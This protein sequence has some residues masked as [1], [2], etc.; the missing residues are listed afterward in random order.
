MFT[1]VIASNRLFITP[2][3]LLAQRRARA[4]RKLCGRRQIVHELYVDDVTRRHDHNVLQIDV[5]NANLR[6]SHIPIPLIRNNE[7]TPPRYQTTTGLPT[8]GS[9]NQLVTPTGQTQATPP[10]VMPPLT[11]PHQVIRQFYCY[12]YHTNL[13]PCGNHLLYAD[14][15]LGSSTGR[16]FTNA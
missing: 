13:K 6:G 2:R 8:S 14:F 9:T 12:M 16:A 15:T 10:P 3:R 1:N 5:Q 4:T 11:P 7:L